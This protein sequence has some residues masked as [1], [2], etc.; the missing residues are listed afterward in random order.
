[1]APSG[2]ASFRRQLVVTAIA[3]FAIVS[4]PQEEVVVSGTVWFVG[5]GLLAGGVVS[6]VLRWPDLTWF[7]STTSGR[8]AI[9]VVSTLCVLIISVAVV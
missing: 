7:A 2:T 1:M 9:G 3:A 8:R 5:V 4:L 6:A